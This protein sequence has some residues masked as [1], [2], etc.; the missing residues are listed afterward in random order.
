MTEP[1]TMIRNLRPRVLA[2][3]S[4]GGM[5]RSFSNTPSPSIWT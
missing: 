3:M 2:I 1:M 5:G 4:S